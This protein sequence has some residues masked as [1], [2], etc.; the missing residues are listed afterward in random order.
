MTKRLYWEDSYQKEFDAKVVSIN[1][2]QLILDQTCFYARAG[3]QVGDTGEID[4]IRV[5]DTMP[6]ENKENVMHI[7]EKEPGFKVDDTVH[8]KIDWERRYRIMR[9]HSAAHLVDHFMKTVYPG[10]NLASPG[11]VD[12]RKIK[13]DYIFPDGLDRAKLV[14]VEKLANEF[15]R[16]EHDIAL[17]W[18]DKGR[19][20][21]KSE[22]ID[23]ECGGTHVRN[24][25]EI[26]T[27]KLDRGKKPGAGRER[28]E[29]V[30][31]G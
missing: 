23:I 30:L 5:I 26:G 31:L 11:I 15:A 3:G 28:I 25:G 8:G 10:C 20:H 29:T 24:T 27:I 13:G 12:E 6:D 2:N 7:L 16:N 17:Y 18:D 22:N 9:S 19:R 4:G 14:E 1:D 21:W